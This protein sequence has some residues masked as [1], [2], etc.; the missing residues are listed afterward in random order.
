M[1]IVLIILGALAA[2]A[3]IIIPLIAQKERIGKFAILIVVGLVIFIAGHS[4]K[5]I[6]TGYTGV[7]ST[8]GQISQETV[9]QGFNL[10]FPFVQK[11]SK[12]NNKQ[13]DTKVKAEVWGE[14]IE[15][16]PV[17]ASD[18]I[19]TYKISP[20]KSSWLY[21]NVTDTDDLITDS[22]VA[23]ALKSAMVE[24]SV[25]DVTNRSKIEPL[26]KDKLGISVNEKYGKDS[27]QILKIVINNMDFEKEYN[28]AI[29]EKSIAKQTQE[30]QKIENETAIAKSEADKK[31]AI[32]NAEA[33]AEAKRIAAE[34]EAEANQ[35]ISNSLTDGVLKS[36]FYEKWDG[37]LP[38]AM[39][40]DTVITNIADSSGSK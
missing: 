11:I 14:T 32:T 25:T 17:F 1:N 9:K 7:R 6:P 19:I 24:L 31:V 38:E 16:T 22:L 26:A 23:S 10:K 3:G 18:V 35:K 40:S 12:V 21:T 4:F 39:G 36:K 20:D 30:K 2:I 5:I 28:Q 37:K 34:A 15:K 8:F 27:I 33:K 13:Q 29:A